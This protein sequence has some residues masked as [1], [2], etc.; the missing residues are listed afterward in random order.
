MATC[1]G[2][3][4]VPRKVTGAVRETT[5]ERKRQMQT[6]FPDPPLVGVASRALVQSSRHQPARL[7][8]R[9]ELVPGTLLRRKPRVEEAPGLGRPATRAT[10]VGAAAPPVGG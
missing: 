2:T 9:R 7:A 5:S 10:W 3:A 8:L 4:A 1:Q 6:G